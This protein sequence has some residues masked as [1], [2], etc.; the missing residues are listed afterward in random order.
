MKTF[1]RMLATVGVALFVAAWGAVGVGYLTHVKI[2]TWTALVFAAAIAT[3]VLFWSLA[4]ILGVTVFEARRK[5][6][7]FLTFRRAE[8]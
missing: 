7:R 1:K 8:D 6:W 2:E 3:E 5:I 4:A